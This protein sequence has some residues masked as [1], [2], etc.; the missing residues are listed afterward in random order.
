MYT[1]KIISFA[2][3]KNNR[4]VKIYR[5]QDKKIIVIIEDKSTISIEMTI[6]PL[7]LLGRIE[8]ISLQDEKMILLFIPKRD[9]PVKDPIL[10]LLNINKAQCVF[11][12]F[13][14]FGSHSACLLP[15][16]T[17]LI[18]Q[19][20]HPDIYS[21]ENDILKHE[22]NSHLPHYIKNCITF[23][24]TI[25]YSSGS[26]LILADNFFKTK[27]SQKVSDEAWCTVEDIE[28]FGNGDIVCSA[29]HPDSFFKHHQLHFFDANLVRRTSV[30]LGY[31]WY[32][33]MFILEGEYVA[34]LT[35][36]EADT[37]LYVE[38]YNNK[39]VNVKN[40]WISNLSKQFFD[41]TPEGKLVSC[42]QLGDITVHNLRLPS[43]FN[44]AFFAVNSSLKSSDSAGLVCE[45]LG[46]F[47]KKIPNTQETIYP[48]NCK[49]V[50][51]PLHT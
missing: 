8:I 6:P 2:A 25:L 10:A 9:S 3:L 48:E 42:S 27:V 21:Y 4:F 5:D 38:V 47:R 17:L 41:V 39:G 14:E 33:A 19:N 11:Q 29:T 40:I 16:N 30:S 34:L 32:H 13:I 26:E 31:H 46:F 18:R 36:V 28:F 50:V 35:M 1:R 24:N 37:A 12:K 49:H 51:S 44:E 43:K 45:Y 20:N 15:N 7:V 23:S 22:K